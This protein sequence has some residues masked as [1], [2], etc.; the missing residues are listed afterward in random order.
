MTNAPQIERIEKDP[1]GPV[2]IP[3]DAYYGPQTAR[4]IANFPIS[5]IR[6]SHFP[7]F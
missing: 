3:V 2:S 7:N 1:L 4:G 5:G 6:I